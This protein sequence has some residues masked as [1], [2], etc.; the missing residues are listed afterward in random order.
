MQVINWLD[1]KLTD[2]DLN[3]MLAQVKGVTHLRVV[4]R[5]LVKTILSQYPWEEREDVVEV[6]DS[7]H[8]YEKDDWVALPK[9]DEQG[10]RPDSWR[11]AK[12]KKIEDT[13]NPVQGPFRVVW[14]DLEGKERLFACNVPT[15]SPLP[16][17]F[18]PGDEEEWDML[19]NELVDVYSVQLREVLLQAIDDGRLDLVVILD[20]ALP[21]EKLIR[22]SEEEQ[23]AIEEAFDIEREGRPYTTTA[24]ILSF[25]R[26]KGWLLDIPDDV[27]CFS[28][29]DYLRQP[30]SDYLSLGDSRWIPRERFAEIDRNVAKRPKVPV[31]P[32][33]V[34]QEQ[35]LDDSLDFED[36]NEVELDEEGRKAL[37]EMGEEE[38]EGEAVISLEEWRRRAPTKPVKLPTITYQN[39]IEGFLPL[40]KDLSKCFP[41]VSSKVLVDIQVIDGAPLPFIVD[42]EEGLVTALDKEAFRRK[43][44]EKEIPGGTYLWLERLGGQRY[45]LF[46][47]PSC[48]EQR[49]P[50]KIADWDEE[51]KPFFAIEEVPMRWEGDPHMFKA[52]LRHVN[53][54]A[55]FREAEE[56]GWS[57]FDAMYYTFP[58]LAK[59]D[60]EGK[61]H[62]TE[63]FNAVFFRRMCSP[64]SVQVE[65]YRRPCFVSLGGGY[66]KFDPSQGI[67]PKPVKRSKRRRRRLSF[68]AQIARRPKKR[69]YRPRKRR[70]TWPEAT[71]PEEALWSEIGKL[72]GRELKTLD[73]GNPFRVVRMNDNYMEI[74]IAQTGKP[75][76]IQRSEIQDAW[77]ELV[78]KGELSRTTIHQKYSEFNPA[79]VAAILAE[80]PDVSYETEPI[81]LFY[82]RPKVPDL[83]IRHIVYPIPF[84]DTPL[85]DEIREALLRQ[86]G[87]I[88]RGFEFTFWEP[89]TP[90]RLDEYLM[91]CIADKEANRFVTPRQVVDLMVNLAQPKP[92][93]RVADICCGTGIFLVKAWRFVQEIYGDKGRLEVYGA[94]NYDKAVE[95]T[96][97]NLQANGVTDF[98]VV[99]ADSLNDEA[100]LFAHRYDLIL[101]NPP[102]GGGQC[103]RFIRRWMDLLKDGGRMVVNVSEGVLANTGQANRELR[104]W[105]AENFEIEAVISL[106]RPPNYQLYG[107]K[108]N[109]FFIRKVKPEQGHKALLVQIEDYAQISSVLDILQ[110]RR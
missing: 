37:K 95:A 35:G 102:F 18:P 84:A 56:L 50:C 22:F 94:D 20:Q 54:E 88:Q 80:L 55:L 7:S 107:A 23:A 97:L 38:I 26:E 34:A 91:E 43:F 64:R 82:R 108:S 3:Q 77:N 6:F 106:P 49:V 109:V 96:R 27:A 67:K 98:T 11:V 39:I 90:E 40:T 60:P 31:I 12:I 4:L 63:L 16:L 103:R 32:S 21:G 86:V 74:F 33:K 62:H 66:Y 52:E 44:V 79:Y 72:V 41:P 101:G 59:L 99:L 47:K 9:R 69:T 104:R 89:R 81:R 93:E 76:K 28:I 8:S 48:S 15:G 5:Q 25:L 105:L 83:G 30:E 68:E 75:R 57:I 2:E 1:L 87:P 70:L 110:G 42:W 46:P 13:E 100:G 78:Q 58:E 61:V 51:G 71:R 19:A 45:R 24:E 53:P 14:V 17:Q 65:L 92:G 73:E 29:E 36:Y 85:S 10:I